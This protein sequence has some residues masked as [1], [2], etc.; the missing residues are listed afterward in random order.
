MNKIKQLT[1]FVRSPSGALAL[2]LG[3]LSGCGS[4][5]IV[6]V[7]DIPAASPDQGWLKVTVRPK[8]AELHVDGRFFGTMDGYR[9]GLLRLP[10]GQHRVELKAPGHYAWYGQVTIDA[11][12]VR[13]ETEL[14]T[15][16]PEGQ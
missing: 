15:S 3:L 7:D 10:R 1:R 12:P 14:V 9:D 16:P 5:L 11:E 13:V 2:T 6:G 4:S 8:N